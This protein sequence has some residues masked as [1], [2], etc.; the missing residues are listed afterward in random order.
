VN[1]VKT[2]SSLLMRLDIL[3]G[4]RGQHS[5]HLEYDQTLNQLLVEMD[6]LGGND[7]LHILVIAA[8]N[9]PEALDPACSGQAV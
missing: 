9:R 1:S 6:G 5:S 8:T 4:K 2:R 3:A 7:D